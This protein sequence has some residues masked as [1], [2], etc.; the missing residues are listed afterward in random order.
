LVSID[1]G[2]D[3]SSGPQG[4]WLREEDHRSLS[5]WTILAPTI[6][7]SPKIWLRSNSTKAATDTQEK[8]PQS[9]QL[10]AQ[11]CGKALDTSTMILDPFYA[12]TD[13]FQ[14]CAFSEVQFMN[15]ME[16][17]IK[18]DTDHGSLKKQNPTL[19]NLLYCRDI[20]QKHLTRLQETVNVIKHPGGHLWPHVGED[21]PR[22]FNKASRARESL[23]RDYEHLVER[24]ETLLE[25]CSKGM[26]VIMSNV[27]LA[28]S[29]RSMVQA[30]AVAKLTLIAFFFIPL[31]FTSSLFSMNIAGFVQGI[32]Q[33]WLWFAV[34]AP[35]CLIS[36]SFLVLD[37]RKF[38][39][40]L[41]SLKAYWRQ[42]GEAV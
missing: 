34:S 42:F 25:R 9:A 38:R 6:Q 26:D 29:R 32:G 17:K 20:I 41:L 31:S 13:L 2:N 3:L 19:S 4:P 35:V 21:H 37:R 22:Q 14:F 36:I 8:F 33:I 12:I 1:A 10:L 18:E 40:M 16:A 39:M 24:A 28:E 7:H 15:I 5:P 23:L 30:Q 27:M 11:H